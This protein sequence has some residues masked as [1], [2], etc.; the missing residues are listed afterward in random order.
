MEL[1]HIITLKKNGDFLLCASIMQINY[2]MSY[3]ARNIQFCTMLE[4][5]A[6]CTTRK[7]DNI[8]VLPGGHAINGKIKCFSLYPVQTLLSSRLHSKNLK[9]KIYKTI[10]LPVVL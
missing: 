7:S 2:F 1:V 3:C 9:I 4:R 6:R 10:I 5:P 8:Y